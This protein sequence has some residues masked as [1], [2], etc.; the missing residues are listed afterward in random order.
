MKMLATAL[1]PDDLF[2]GE[3][4]LRSF[5]ANALL[6]LYP[7]KGAGADKDKPYVL[8]A[9]APRTVLGMLHLTN[10]RLVFKALDRNDGSFSVFLPAIAEAKNMSFFFVR[11]FRITMTDGT[12]IDFIR[13]RVAPFLA[14]LNP[15]RRAAADLDWHSIG[16]EIQHQAYKTGDWSVRA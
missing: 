12:S 4:L 10:Y 14:A 9:S 5:G 2:S 6:P 1:T 8:G 13:W 16:Q 11:K 15:A 3:R 7:G